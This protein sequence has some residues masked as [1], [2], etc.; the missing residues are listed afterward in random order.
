MGASCEAKCDANGG[1]ETI[2]EAR[3]R[4]EL[5]WE[6]GYF[7]VSSLA[8]YVVPGCQGILPDFICLGVLDTHLGRLLFLDIQASPRSPYRA[9]V[10]LPNRQK[11][12]CQFLD[13]AS[14]AGP[15]NIKGPRRIHMLPLHSRSQVL[16]SD[17]LFLL[18]AKAVD[19]FGIF[20]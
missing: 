4:G 13:G 20:R 6:G 10:R 16:P 9:V 18:R 5:E 19:N 14:P 11:W 1:M 8:L 7:E 12:S 15:E 3:E 2:K 17:T